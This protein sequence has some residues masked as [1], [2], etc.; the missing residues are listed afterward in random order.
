MHF[1]HHNCDLHIRKRSIKLFIVKFYAVSKYH[2]TFHPKFLFITLVVTIAISCQNNGEEVTFD[3]LTEFIDALPLEVTYPA[4]NPYSL[5]KEELGRLLFWDPILSG[6][7]DVACVSCHH[8]DFGYADGLVH[9]QGVGANGLGPNRNGG[10]KTRRNAPTI[11]N[12][13]YNGIATN[14][15]YN[16]ELAPMFWDNRATSLEEQ[17]LL[18]MLSKEEMRGSAI[19]EASIMDTIVQRLKSIEQ[20]EEMFE[21]AFGANE[22]NQENILAAIATFE[23]GIVAFNSPFDQYMRGDLTALSNF[24]IEGMNLFIEVGCADCHSGPMF[25]D[26]ELHTIGVIDNVNPADRGATEA[27]DFRTPTLRNLDI[28]APYMH[29]GI[30]NTL[31]EVMEFYEQIAEGDE[32]QR[33]ANLLQDDLD[34]EMLDLGLDE[35]EIDA[36][37]AFMATLN[38]ENFD[39]RAPDSVPSGLPVGG[40]INE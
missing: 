16:P 20:Y 11:I 18:P 27:F 36:I 14:Q 37:I 1:D 34:E 31:E 2:F 13:A 22:I 12:S 35:N 23:R 5:E 29:N 15:V 26:F 6:T 9:S 30:H 8:P 33:N 39:K 32:D 4:D 25:S 28:T 17:A 10:L 3:E 40:N 7:K 21:S 19:N 24:E 38:D